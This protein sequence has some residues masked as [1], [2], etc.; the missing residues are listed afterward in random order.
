MY[1]GLL[2]AAKAERSTPPHCGT[3]CRAV[4][5]CRSPCWRRSNASSRSRFTK[6]TASPKRRRLRVSIKRITAVSREPS[7]AASG[8]SISRSPI[9]ISTTASSVADGDSARSSFAA[10]RSS[11]DISTIPKPRAPRSST[12]WFRSGDLGTRDEDG[13]ITIVDRKKDM[14]LRGGYNVYPREVEEV[15]MRHPRVQQVAVIGVPHDAHG[16]E[17][18]AVIVRCA[19]GAVRRGRIDLAWSQEHLGKVQVSATR[20]TSID[21]MPL[22]PSGKVL[23]RELRDRLHQLQGR[24][25]S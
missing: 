21:A 15:L 11:K 12:D 10:M 24:T 19:D 2:E 18:V 5:R 6:A 23:K 3:R 7:V 20:C 25:V 9:P 17:V 8:A 16:E 1:I 14:I 4:R 13:F 22:G